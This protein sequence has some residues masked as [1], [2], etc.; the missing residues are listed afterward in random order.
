MRQIF[1]SHTTQYSEKFND[2]ANQVQRLF[3]VQYLT[4]N[5]LQ[6]NTVHIYNYQPMHGDKTY[7]AQKLT[8]SWPAM[9][10]FC[11]VVMNHFLQQT[12]AKSE[13]HRAS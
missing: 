5:F 2:D 6:V 1:N 4:I 10:P 12:R 3:K 7:K 9:Q 11:M 13:K 8:A